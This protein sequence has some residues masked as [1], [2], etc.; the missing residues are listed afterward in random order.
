MFQYEV[1]ERWDGKFNL[2]RRRGNNGPW[3]IVKVFFNRAHAEKTAEQLN[4]R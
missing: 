4:K 3:I 2:W 1:G